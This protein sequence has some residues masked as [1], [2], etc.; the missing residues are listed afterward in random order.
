MTACCSLAGIDPAVKER[1]DRAGQ[2]DLI[3]ADRVFLAGNV[4]GESTTDALRAGEAW[5]AAL[6]PCVLVTDGR[7]SDPRQRRTVRCGGDRAVG[8]FPGFRTG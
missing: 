7:A 4:I 2:L 5:L 8:D 3:G 1:M 6:P